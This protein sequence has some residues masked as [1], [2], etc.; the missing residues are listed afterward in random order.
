MMADINLTI[1]NLVNH[2]MGLFL[3]NKYPH[4]FISLDVSQ[5]LFHQTSI[6]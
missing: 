4:N 5:V 2:D 1:A 6:L 3:K